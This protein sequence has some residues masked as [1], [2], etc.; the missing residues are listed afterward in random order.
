MNLSK[1]N[2][3]EASDI[4]ENFMWKH[5]NIHKQKILKMKFL[6][7][8]IA[9]KT[10]A[11]TLIVDEMNRN[12]AFENGKDRF[13]KGKVYFLE[14]R[15]DLMKK[16]LEDQSKFYNGYY[17][18]LDFVEK[19][20]LDLISGKIKDVLNNFKKEI[21]GTDEFIENIFN[22]T[23]VLGIFYRNGLKSRFNEIFKMIKFKE[24]K[25]FPYCN[26]QYYYLLTLKEILNSNIKRAEIIFKKFENKIDSTIYKRDFKRKRLFLLSE[27]SKKKGDFKKS[28]QYLLKIIKE[29]HGVNSTSYKD[30]PQPLLLFSLSKLY[31]DNGKYELSEKWFKKLLN[32]YIA[33]YS[34]GDLYARTYFYLGKIYL[35]K[36]WNGKAIEYFNKFLKC[37][38][39]GDKLITHNYLKEVKNY[40]SEIK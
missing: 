22:Y 28:E 6:L 25:D 4:I 21:L 34:N 18:R 40:L 16:E 32:L 39:D 11:A 2:Y 10:E 36:N 26:V 24:N 33:N 30:N 23:E 5:P 37:W 1:K 20:Y 15:W 8:L 27:F 35:K 17:F 31:F 19:K 38:K 3:K 9:G 29:L 14:N 7:N 12:L 13:F